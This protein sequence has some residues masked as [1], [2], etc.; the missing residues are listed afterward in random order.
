M[1]PYILFVATTPKNHIFN[2]LY[3]NKH[4]IH[5]SNNGTKWDSASIGI[6]RERIEG[7][8]TDQ[9]GFIY[10]AMNCLYRGVEPESLIPPVPIGPTNNVDGIEKLPTISWRT[11]PKADL[12]ELQISE[13]IDFINVLETVVQSDTTYK[14]QYPIDNGKMYVWRV[15]SKVNA[16]YS[17][18]SPLNFFR[19]IF[20]APDLISPNNNSTGLNKNITF[21]WN[22]VTDVPYYRI[23]VSEDASFNNAIID[24][25]NISDTTTESSIF[26]N[27]KTYFW[28][29][30]AESSTNIGDWSETWKFRTKLNAPKLIAPDS[31]IY[32]LLKNIKLEWLKSEGATKYIVLLSKQN[33]FS[34]IIFTDTTDKL[35]SYIDLELDYFS[36]YYW[37]VKA[38]EDQGESDWSVIWMFKTVI[39]A[40]ELVSPRNTA[41]DILTNITFRWTKYNYANFYHFQLSKSDDFSTLIENDSNV[42]DPS[43]EIRNLEYF[44]TYHWRVRIKNFT[45]YGLWS[46]TWAFTTGL[47]TPIL[48]Y[49]KNE[50]TEIPPDLY[51]KWEPLKGADYYQLQISKSDLFDSLIVDE[52]LINNTEFL[53][54]GLENE[55]KYYWR[56]KGKY[57]QGVSEWSE[58]WH[59]ETRKVNN[60]F[61]VDNNFKISIHPNPFNEFVTFNIFAEGITDIK[62]DI[63]DLYGRL[64]DS[65]NS[66][67]VGESKVLNWIWKPTSITQGIYFYK[68]NLNGY[69]YYGKVIYTE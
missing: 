64:I 11:A 51:I 43:F 15:R 67:N 17:K 10:L 22:K 8:V 54:N 57:S 33:D 1:S 66:Q 44:T 40:P 2:A 47:A 55:T 35:Y 32:G 38:I 4:I 37:K 62:I 27:Y 13:D 53:V 52:D 20:P 25:T 7:M 50:A 5:S 49:P 9:D 6:I 30:R 16:S 19:T 23:Q 24:K 45:T 31:G 34:T 58:V 61:D 42:Y 21:L 18:W 26:Q 28:K 68:I 3:G 41:V 65:Y 46:N 36:E 12:Y 60:V 48:T 29:V 39:N 14:L 69:S 56:V 63:L 59:F